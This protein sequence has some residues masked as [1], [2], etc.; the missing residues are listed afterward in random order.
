MI[1]LAGT[2]GSA[3]HKGECAAPVF[4]ASCLHI[5]TSLMGAQQSRSSS[6]SATET[7]THRFTRHLRRHSGLDKLFKS[8][9]NTETNESEGS[10][11]SSS[12]SEGAS[13]PAVTPAN[14]GLS[15]GT[16]GGGAVSTA[17]PVS[18]VVLPKH[19]PN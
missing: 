12:S 3:I 10:G 11:S 5:I 6:S 16:L 1:S 14:G 2:R 9:K 15:Q 8:S 18:V 19:Y 13:T 7:H 17:T 4:L